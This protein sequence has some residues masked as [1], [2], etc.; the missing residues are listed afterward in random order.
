YRETLAAVAGDGLR[1]ARVWAFGEGTG[2][3]DEWSRRHQLFRAGPDGWQGDAYLHLDRVVAEAGA[4]GVRLIVTLA[5]NWS[6]Y[7]GI[8]MYLGWAG[9]SP[10]DDAPDDNDPAREA[11]YTDE[12]VR[13]FF[14]AGVERL[15][16]RTNSVTG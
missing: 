9:L 7:G 15:L 5:N 1:V 6:D 3:A 10:G 14:R 2:D 8:P 16:A 4:R 12:R 13:A 11:F